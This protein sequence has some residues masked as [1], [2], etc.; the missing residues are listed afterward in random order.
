MSLVDFAAQCAAI[1][2][3]RR[4]GEFARHWVFSVIEDAPN[5]NL[6]GR[7]L[8]YLPPGGEPL[9]LAP[10]R[11]ARGSPPLYYVPLPP[12]VPLKPQ[13]YKP[14]VRVFQRQIL[15]L[16]GKTRSRLGPST[17]SCLEVGDIRRPYQR[18]KGETYAQA[19]ER[20]VRAQ[21]V[22]VIDEIHNRRVR[23]ET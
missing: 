21:A 6:L 17:D 9:R 10:P 7:V 8:D 18:L 22:A 19:E 1:R 4:E 12:T 15:K 5:R 11:H 23:R 14:R 20:A 13:P 2:I 16:D 3:F